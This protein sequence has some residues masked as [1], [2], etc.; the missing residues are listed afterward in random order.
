MIPDPFAGDGTSA[1][2]PLYAGLAAVTNAAI[3]RRLGFL[4]PFLYALGTHLFRGITGPPGPPDNGLNGVP[5]YPAVAGW[6]ACT[7][8]G[9]LKGDLLLSMLVGELA[10]AGKVER[11]IFDHFGDFEGFVL[12]TAHGELRHF[13]SREDRVFDLIERAW[14]Q[15][16]AVTIEAEAGT[17][18][19]SVSFDLPPARSPRNG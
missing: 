18:I 14:E 5:G 6:N 2:A 17:K 16:L 19:R 13:Y 7:G 11:I 15:R 10:H 3:G 4:N 9:V 8:W 1:S 12:E